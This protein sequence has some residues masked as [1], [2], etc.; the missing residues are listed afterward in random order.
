MGSDGMH[1]RNCK[2]GYRSEALLKVAPD[3]ATRTIVQKAAMRL[4]E[5]VPSQRQE[6]LS[7]LCAQWIEIA[8]ECGLGEVA[9]Y[10]QVGLLAEHVLDFVAEI[11]LGGGSHSDAA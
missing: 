4:L 5:V 1:D 10:E 9:A 3:A 11:E 6:F 2:Q 7:W 8:M